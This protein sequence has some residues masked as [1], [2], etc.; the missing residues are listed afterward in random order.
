MCICNTGKMSTFTQEKINANTHTQR[1]GG[2]GADPLLCPH[3]A[4]IDLYGG[5][6]N[7]SRPIG[8]III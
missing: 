1:D 6:I 5:W 3:M 7:G 8:G 2:S 4:A